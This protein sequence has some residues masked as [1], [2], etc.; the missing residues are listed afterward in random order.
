[1]DGLVD[2]IGGRVCRCVLYS[3]DF[4]ASKVGSLAAISLIW[5]SH[6]AS[7]SFDN[8]SS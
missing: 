5:A 3:D 4:L 8:F 7:L 1:M 2:G 6:G